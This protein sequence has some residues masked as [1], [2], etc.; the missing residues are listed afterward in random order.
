[1]LWGMRRARGR[2]GSAQKESGRRPPSGRRP[3]CSRRLSGRRAVVGFISMLSITVGLRAPASPGRRRAGP[4]RSHGCSAGGGRP[5]PASG[6]G[7]RAGCGRNRLSAAVGFAVARRTKFFVMCE[8]IAWGGEK[9]P[10]SGKRKAFPLRGTA[11]GRGAVAFL[12]GFQVLDLRLD[13]LGRKESK[14]RNR[15]HRAPLQAGSNA[16]RKRR[17]LRGARSGRRGGVATGGLPVSGEHGAD[18]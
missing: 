16:A 15:A 7:H 17:K 2:F 9:P 12:S 5:E 3:N 8:K 18:A 13:G 1:M 4:G 10:V 6:N 14:G 11:G